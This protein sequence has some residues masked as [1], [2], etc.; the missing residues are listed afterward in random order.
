M[1]FN[2]L[3]WSLRARSLMLAG[4][5]PAEY[6]Q[7]WDNLEAEWQPQTHSERHYM[8]QMCESQWLLTR[9]ACS[10]RRVHDANMKL[11]EEFALLDRISLQRVR[12][13]RSFTTAKRELE[14]LQLK[15][16][17]RS[18]PRPAPAAKAAPAPVHQPAAPNV[19]PPAYVMSESAGDQPAFCAT[20]TPDTR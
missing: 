13:E 3:T 6:Q 8:E 1:R 5:D 19:P 14:R 18:Q 4:D 7:L 11:A 15:R 10:E 9:M 12:L 16:Q 17:A 20:V 2:A